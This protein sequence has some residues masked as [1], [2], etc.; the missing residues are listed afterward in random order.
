M[1]IV[2]CTKQVRHTYA[3]TGKDPDKKYINPEDSIFRINPYDEAALELALRVKDTSGI[4]EITLLTVG[5]M[6]AE[7]QLRRCL[8]TGADHLYQIQS[9]GLQGQSEPLNQPDPWVKSDVLA[10]AIKELGGDIV[11]CGKE[12]ID[13]GNAQVGAFLA[14]R[15][16]YP[17]VSA[18]T[19]LE[20]KENNGTVQIRRSAGRGVREIIECALPAVFSVDLGSD[21]RLPLFEKKKWAA[22]YPIGQ[23]ELKEPNAKAKIVCTDIFQPKPR[24]KI[25]PPPD[26]S[27]NAYDRIQHLLSGSRVEKKGQILDGDPASQV[28]GFISFLDEHGFLEKKE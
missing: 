10:G 4:S 22:A 21:L 13:K 20:I 7:A 17:F 26:S 23:L 5:P 15:L 1:K 11:L 16:N 28:D 9:D 12:S 8:A 3:R 14:K 24:P 6:I 18:I 19:D 27:L 2:V 25:V